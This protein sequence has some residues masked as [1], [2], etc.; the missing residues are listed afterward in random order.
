VG[1]P[2]DQEQAPQEEGWAARGRD[3]FDGNPATRLAQAGLP[4]ALALGIDSV[5]RIAPAPEVDSEAQPVP[6]RTNAETT[7]SRTKA[8]PQISV[9]WR[10][11]SLRISRDGL[12]CGPPLP[13]VA[14]SGPLLR[15]SADGKWSPSLLLIRN[16]LTRNATA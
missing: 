7:T 4:T 1:W 10:A 6:E 11:I 15:A 13:P 16:Q 8:Q 14:R 5:V 3:S 12:R 9:V 2:Y